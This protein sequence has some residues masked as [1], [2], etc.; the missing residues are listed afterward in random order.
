MY[1]A[2]YFR[3][4]RTWEGHN[5]ANC[6]LLCAIQLQYFPD[7]ACFKWID[8]SPRNVARP[9]P[10]CSGEDNDVVIVKAEEVR[11]PGPIIYNT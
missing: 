11:K 6:Q 7:C 3:P 8:Q 10:Q 5:V 9:T 2:V 1:H 4:E